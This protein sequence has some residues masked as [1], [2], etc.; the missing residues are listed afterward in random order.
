MS[1]VPP[2]QQVNNPPASFAGGHAQIA[3]QIP[4]QNPVSNQVS[5]SNIDNSVTDN[6]EYVIG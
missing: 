1:Y 3:N 5:N 2:Q 4:V 6:S